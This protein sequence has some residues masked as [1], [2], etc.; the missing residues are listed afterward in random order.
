MPGI[1][2][3]NDVHQD[4]QKFQMCVMARNM[5]VDQPIKFDITRFQTA[6][7]DGRL[8]GDPDTSVGWPNVDTTSV[9]SSRRWANLSPT[10][11]A[12]WGRMGMK[13]NEWEWIIPK[14]AGNNRGIRS[15]AGLSERAF[16]EVPVSLVIQTKM[17]FSPPFP[18]A[19]FILEKLKRK[20]T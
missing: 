14:D 5:S 10:V 16:L 11:I 3:Q 18:Y 8:E 2:I 17:W 19:I 7:T 4:N 13:P 1:H 9:L 6:V 12:V 15:S 20:C